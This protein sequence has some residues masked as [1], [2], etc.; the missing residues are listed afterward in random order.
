MKKR[1]VITLVLGAAF[2]VSS[3]GADE[4]K[5]DPKE[6]KKREYRGV[7]VKKLPWSIP[8]VKDIPDNKYGDLVK[9]GRELIVN[10]SKYIGPEVDDPAM[11]FAGN[12]NHCQNCHLDAGTKAYSAPHT[13][14]FLSIDQE[15]MV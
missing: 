14:S 11:R 9:Y 3:F 13:E 8:D 7:E 6:L 10:T 4:V 12:N 15:R 5:F 2:A 1:T